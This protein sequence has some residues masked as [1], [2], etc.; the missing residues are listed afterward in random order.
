LRSVD[1]DARRTDRLGHHQAVAFHVAGFTRHQKEVTGVSSE[2]DPERA[3]GTSDLFPRRVSQA[4]RGVFQEA[5]FSAVQ[6][7]FHGS[8]QHWALA[9]D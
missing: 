1:P 9:R 6:D 7:E 4:D 8:L 2:G 5:D 3:G